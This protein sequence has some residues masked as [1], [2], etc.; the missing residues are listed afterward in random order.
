MT[1]INDL[2]TPVLAMNNLPN[3][4]GAY[5]MHYDETNN[6][7]RLHLTPDGLNVRAPQCFVL[8]GIAHRGA[9]PPLD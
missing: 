8:G 9:P 7:R 4:D 3:V 5:T 1:D 6:I 2:R